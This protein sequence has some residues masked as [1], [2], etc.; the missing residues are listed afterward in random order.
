MRVPFVTAAPA[1]RRPA[2]GGG[3][4]P[5]C[6]VGLA[7]ALWPAVGCAPQ[8]EATA[9]P[10][11]SPP[12]APVPVASDGPPLIVEP[13]AETP[14]GLVWVP[15]GRFLMGTNFR[16]APDRPNPDRIKPDESPAHEVELDGFWMKATPVTNREFAEF[17]AMTGFRTFAERIPTREELLHSGLDESQIDE[18]L[19]RPT[20]ICFN[21]HFDAQNLIVGPQ[22]WEYQVWQIVEGAD[23]RHPEG[24]DSSIDGREE[25]PVVHVNFYDAQAFCEWIGAQLPTEAQFEYAARSGGKPVKYPWGNDLAPGGEEL[26]N[27][28]QGTFPT[29]H[30]NRDG[31]L[32]TSPVRSF[33][34]NEL[35]L[36]DMAG[37]VW[38]W[39]RD[40]YD[41]A[42]YSRSPRRNPPG[43]ARSY[44]PAAPPEEARQ[45]KRVQRGGSF[46]CNVNNCTGYRCTARMRGEELSSSFHCGFRYVVE[47][48]RLEVYRQ[49]QQAIAAWRAAQ[50]ATPP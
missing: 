49:R 15:G 46:M 18:R 27:Y 19:F 7:L 31:F 43:P 45:T 1:A 32:V 50:A 22:N 48:G 36:Y 6:L 26:C 24:P 17:V 4:K 42:Y 44:D 12:E 38:E 2:P 25:H 13:P 9:V 23:W 8:G 10:A 35:G 16:P 41:A 33:P 37:N 20:S 28:F 5:L 11:S 30:I 39:C 47:P 34:P 21:R 14:D 40:L 3:G 29:Q